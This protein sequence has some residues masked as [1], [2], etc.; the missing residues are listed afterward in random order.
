MH[1][2][3]EPRSQ[4]GL[5]LFRLIS[6]VIGVNQVAI[7][8]LTPN[9]CDSLCLGALLAYLNSREYGLFM[10]RK[11][12]FFFFL[13]GLFIT[14]VLPALLHSDANGLITSTLA[15]TGRGLIFTCLVAA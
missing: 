13:T 2:A 4:L 5:P 12:V 7:W 9:A 1:L 6:T 8:V 15:D 3:L 14:I 11:I 10:S